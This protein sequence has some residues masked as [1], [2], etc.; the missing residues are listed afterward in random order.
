MLIFQSLLDH[1]ILLFPFFLIVPWLQSDKKE[2]VVTCIHEAEQAETDHAGRVLDPRHL[3]H[4]LLN[5]PRNPVRAVEGSS[6][7]KL[8]IEIDV[9]LVLI[10]QEA[11]LQSVAGAASRNAGERPQNERNRPFG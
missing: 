1:M 2:R 11:G 4:D 6:V 3:G 7:W 5:S 9:A 10:G 8:E